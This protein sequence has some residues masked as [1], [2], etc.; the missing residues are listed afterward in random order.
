MYVK[1]AL[2]SVTFESQQMGSLSRLNVETRSHFVLA[3]I[4]Q[5][6]NDYHFHASERSERCLLIMIRNKAAW[7]GSAR[8]GKKKRAKRAENRTPWGVDK[9]QEIPHRLQKFMS[10][11]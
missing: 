9:R 3:L 4:T 7:F 8:H 11:F 1:C 5:Y 2:H 10:F 6:E